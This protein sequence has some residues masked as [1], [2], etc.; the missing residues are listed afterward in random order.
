[1]E[2]SHLLSISEKRI[3]S[4]APEGYSFSIVAI[5]LAIHPQG[6]FSSKETK[7]KKK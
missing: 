7:K 2:S 5:S 1:L 3:A 6:A 4:V